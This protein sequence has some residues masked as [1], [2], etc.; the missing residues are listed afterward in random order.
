MG[1]LKEEGRPET[2]STPT[3]QFSRD[4][5][6][7]ELGINHTQLYQDLRLA[8]ALD[9]QPELAKKSS[10]KDAMREIK[11]REKIAKIK[12]ELEKITTNIPD[13]VI[14]RNCDFRDRTKNEIVDNSV[15][16]V[17]TDPPYRIIDLP[18]YADLAKESMRV[19]KEG[20]VLVCY[21]ANHEIGKIINM[22]EEQGMKYHWLCHIIH[23]GH[24]Q[25]FHPYHVIIGAKPM[26]MFTKGKYDGNYFE[27]TIFSKFE[28][29]ELHEWAQSTVESDK[30]I[31]KMSGKGEVVY[32]PMLGSGTFGISAVKLGRQFI[33]V[34][35]NEEHYETSRKQVSQAVEGNRSTKQ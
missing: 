23:S 26:L 24:N 28:G 15:A 20:G 19:L 3:V 30:F 33:G 32:D 29:K 16:L 11:K 12:E 5:V 9:T 6:A 10:K 14:L 22:V 35:I 7:K 34:E 13:G 4:E 25:T 27:D 1:V 21:V 8:K 17:I 18:I 2:N 31:E